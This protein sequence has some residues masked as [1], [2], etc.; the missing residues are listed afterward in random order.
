MGSNYEKVKEESPCWTCGNACGGCSWSR[1]SMPVPGWDADANILAD[2]TMR[3]Y[4]IHHCPERIPDDH[5]LF[6]DKEIDTSGMLALIEAMAT[7]MRDDY[8]N[9]KG[10]YDE[11]KRMTPGEIRTANR[12][13]I[14]K[15]ILSKRGRNLMQLSSPDDVING[16][17]QLA[18]RHDADSVKVLHNTFKG[19]R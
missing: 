11:N 8:V 2:G 14:E 16:L 13:H 15:F 5:E 7:C 4:V 1:D 3:G 19:G 10:P 17:R 18:R 9:G 6:R 12:N